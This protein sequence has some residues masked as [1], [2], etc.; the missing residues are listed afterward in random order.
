MHDRNVQLSI[1]TAVYNN[2]LF[3]REC[4]ENVID[5]NCKLIEHIIIDGGSEDGT[6]EVIEGYARRCKHIRWI[7]EKD[8]GQS[9]AI[10]KGLQMAKG[11]IVSLLNVDDYYE[12]NVFQE[13]LSIFNDNPDCNMLIGN[14][15]VWGEGEQHLYINRPRKLKLEDL[16]L[17]FHVNPFPIN[18]SAYFYHASLHQTVGLYSLEEHYVLDVD[19]LFR[20]VSVANIKYVDRVFGNYRMLSGTKT[21]ESIRSGQSSARVERLIKKYRQQLPTIKRINLAFQYSLFKLMRRIRNRLSL[22]LLIHGMA[23]NKM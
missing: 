11:H 15:N 3:I 19:F 14:C 20:A 2:V 8:F 1:I 18:P 10:N 5:Q 9:H 13:V 22:D 21:V 17:G 4:I 12:P 23:S 7:S 6:K 16:L